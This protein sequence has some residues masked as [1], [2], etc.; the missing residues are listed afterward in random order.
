MKN[1]LIKKLN[2]CSYCIFEDILSEEQRDVR[3]L[4]KGIPENHAHRLMIEEVCGNGY[5]G[6]CQM[7]YLA[8]RSQYDDFSLAQ[9]GAIRHF[10]EDYWDKNGLS[11]YKGRKKIEEGLMLWTTPSNLG[12][13]PPES[14]AQRFREVWD[15]GLRGENQILTEEG[16]YEIVTTKDP[17]E[18]GN[19]IDSLNL[20][21]SNLKKSKH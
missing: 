16:I 11:E 18:Y 21:K 5:D 19:L 7:K 12:R 15:L 8:M 2:E 17:F 20:L 13:N 3:V 1:E 10:L 9:L 14:Y 4:E 6:V